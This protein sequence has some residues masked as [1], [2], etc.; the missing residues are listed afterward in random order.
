MYD[1]SCADSSSLFPS[2]A[3]LFRCVSEYTE[4]GLEVTV[5]LTDF[6]ASTVAVEVKTVSPG[7]H[8]FAL[9]IVYVMPVRML[10]NNLSIS[11]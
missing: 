2:H 9:P 4:V 10:I 11:P 7:Q 3:S 1:F 5:T 8:L 6:A